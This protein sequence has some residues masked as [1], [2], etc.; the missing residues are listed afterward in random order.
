MPARSIVA[1]SYLFPPDPAIGG[2]R[3][4]RFM[5]HLARRHGWSVQVVTPARK[6]MQ[7]SCGLQDDELPDAMTVWRTGNVELFDWVRRIRGALRRPQHAPADSSTQPN[8]SLANAPDARAGRRRGL[9]RSI[10]ELLAVP[11]T[12]IGWIPFAVARG[13]WCVRRAGADGVL[14]S[15]GPPHSA[16]VAAAIIKRITGRPWIADLRDPWTA[17]P[18]NPDLGDA[19]ERWNSVLEQYCV[20]RADAV[21]C[22][23]EAAREHFFITYPQLAG[24]IVTVPNGYDEEDFEGLE[25]EAFWPADG[26]L[27][28]LHA[29]SM[30]GKRSPQ[31]L[32]Q[33]LAEFRKEQPEQCPHVIFLG[34]PSPEIRRQADALIDAEGLRDVVS[35]HPPLPRRQALAAQAAADGLVLLG[36]AAPQR[37]QIPAK[38]FE[39]LR[40]QKPVLSLFPEGAPVEP[41]MEQY[42][43][44][45][46]RANPG[47]VPEIV[48]ALR[49]FCREARRPA[50]GSAEIRELSRVHQA[51][52]LHEILELSRKLRTCDGRV[53]E[54][55]RAGHGDELRAETLTDRASREPGG[56]L[57]PITPDRPDT[58]AQQF[59]SA[60]IR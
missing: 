54:K 1:L 39:Y 5:A 15:S 21:L 18:Y 26:R 45:Y 55:E 41:Y 37:L 42:A 2:I 3:V 49:Q 6:S 13:L 24:H 4:G 23:T 25:P 17:N 48:E 35:F 31:A 46:R 28:L 38:V 50:Q 44:H 57:L 47:D 8:A 60:G 7:G 11:D 58:A 19:A 9:L 20:T 16:H 10:S 43:P 14:F 34:N 27:V 51:E 59:R 12:R 52:T 32:L 33:A 22:N 29:G 36:D 56:I 53:R 40:L 30:Y